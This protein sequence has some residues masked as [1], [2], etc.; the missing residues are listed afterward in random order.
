MTQQYCPSCAEE[1]P[2]RIVGDA[3][4]DYLFVGSI[5]DDEEL[6]YHK[7]F[8][9]GAGHIFRRE[10]FKIT[11]VDL[12]FSRLA[13]LWYHAPNK[14]ENCLS[15]SASLVVEEMIGRKYIILVGAAAVKYFTDLSVDKVNGLEVT[16]CVKLN[17]TE[18]LNT[19]QSRA[20]ALVNPSTVFNRGVGELRF[21]LQNIRKLIENDRA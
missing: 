13:M 12:S 7:P 14:N 6:K 18:Y 3:R 9:G 2:M 1:V 11:D 4:S 21:G 17:E 8:S 20:F 10:L 5:P 15:V 16:E 19:N